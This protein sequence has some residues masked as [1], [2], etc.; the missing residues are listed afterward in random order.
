MSKS[1]EKTLLTVELM[2]RGAVMLK[3]PCPIDNGVQLRYKG[4]TFCT[5]HD[6]LEAALSSKEV[7]YG[8]VASSLRDLVLVKLK[9]NAASLETEKDIN[10]QDEIISLISKCVDLLNKLD[11]SSQRT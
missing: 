3:E 2:R 6:D 4:K 11:A 7:T 9:E 8:D 1:R 5:T 10:K